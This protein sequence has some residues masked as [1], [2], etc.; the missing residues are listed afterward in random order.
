[1]TAKQILS[2][3]ALGRAPF[4][5]FDPFLFCVHHLDAYP[6]GEANMGPDPAA[7]RNRDLGMDFS[8][9][10]GWSMYHG[11]TVPGFPAHPHRGFET[12]TVTRRGFVDHSDSLG[13]TARYGQGDTQWMTAGAGIQ[14]SEMFPLLERTKPNPMELY[15]I[16]LNL[17]RAKKMCPPAFAMLWAEATPVVEA[18]TGAR[19]TVVAG[20]LFGAVPPPPPPDSWAADASNDVG[21]WVVELPADGAS[22]VLPAAQRGTRRAVYVIRGD[23][24]AVGDA[25]EG[26]SARTG[27]EVDSQSALSLRATNGAVELLVLQGKPIGEPVAQHGP[28]VMNTRDEIRQAF[29]DYQRT[30]FGGWSFGN[31][32]PV[33]GRGVGRHA[34]HPDGHREDAPSKSK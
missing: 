17:P 30:R 14:H 7:L 13:C 22:V 8:Y 9:E 12:V 25:G 15:Q 26:L 19:V 10:D 28:M 32:A 33:H 34:V 18:P 24:V 2:T 29:E 11:A 31:P 23:G 21:V 5:T 27:A 16:W 3:F 1:M 4:K 20:R 6:A